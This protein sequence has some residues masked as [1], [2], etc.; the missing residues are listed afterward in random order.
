[1]VISSQKTE[2]SKAFG[3]FSLQETRSMNES[4]IITIAAVKLFSEAIEVCI[5]I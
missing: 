5:W 1:M 4:S 3:A 2:R